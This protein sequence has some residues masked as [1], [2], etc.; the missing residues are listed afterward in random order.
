[1]A[2]AVMFGA[3]ACSQY[4]EQE[5]VEGQEVTTTF[6]IGLENLGTRVAGDSGMIDKVAWGIYEHQADGSGRFLRVHSSDNP[7]NG[8]ADFDGEKAEIEVTLFTGK[9]YDLVFF[10]YCSANNAYSIDWEARELNVDYSDLANLETRDAFYHVEPAF[11]A[12]TNKTFTLR[13]PFAQLNVGQSMEDFGIMQLTGNYIEKSSVTVKAYSKMK[14]TATKDEN[15]QIINSGPVVDES[16]DV[17][18]LKMNNVVSDN[19]TVNEVAY[20]HIAMNY[21]LV[22]EKQV[23]ND[24]EFKFTENTTTGAPTEFTRTYHNVPLQRNY[25]TNILGRIISDEYNFEIVI[26]ADFNEPD[27][28]IFHAFQHGGV[29]DLTSNTEVS[30]PQIVQGVIKDGVEQFVEVVLNLNGHTIENK[31]GNKTQV[32]EV[33]KGN[34]LTINGEGTLVGGSAADYGFI[35]HGDAV[36]N[37][38]NINSKGGGVGVYGGAKVTF[39][40]DVYVDSPSTSGRYVF[41]TEDAGSELTIKSGNFAWDPSDN[42]RRAYINA[43]AGTTVHVKGGNFGKPST[44][45]E[46][47]AGILGTGEVII[48]GGTFG[49]DPSAWVAPGYT[50]IKE[51]ATWTVVYGTVANNADALNAALT[52]GATVI[53]SKNVNYGAIT[54]GELKDVTILGTEGSVLNFVTDANS[55]LENVTLKKVNFVYDGSNVN[56]GIVIN[57]ESQIENLVV[58]GCS[59]TGTGEKKGRGIYGQN[60]TATIVLKNCNFKN[61]GYPIYTMA[62]GGYESLVVEGCTF[63]LIKSWAIMPQYNDYAGDLTVTGCTFTNCTGGLVKAGAFT[64]GHTFTFTNNTVTNSSEH[65]AKNWFTIDTAAASKVVEGNTKDG[66]AWT[67]GAAEGLK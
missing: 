61:L 50:A 13:R 54:A 24:V 57:A 52:D 43:E 38:V 41:Y 27:N 23:V 65:P 33:A 66:A 58:E 40:G 11:T 55:K 17:V 10:G 36:L 59:F 4:D 37:N 49:F 25:R 7:D 19:L 21:L 35:A 51:G 47:K 63:E 15:G 9:K 22:N 56:S 8:P 28:I 48:T 60:P 34:K 67:P 62:G 20:K 64:A 53:L 42:Q 29:V 6:A 31:G 14:L 32:I 12:G 18:T 46:Y 45:S 30:N 39:S 3:V 1:M 44:R 2:A 5:V 26:D 16:V